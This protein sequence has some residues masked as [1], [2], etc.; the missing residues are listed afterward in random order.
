MDKILV[1][2]CS[3]TDGHDWPTHLWPDASVINMAKSGAS[4]QY[5]SDSIMQSIDL[6]SK[7]DFVFILWT[8]LN[9]LD[10]VLPVSPMTTALAETHKYYG[11]INNSYY[12]FDGGNKYVHELTQCYQQIKDSSWP[13]VN[14]LLDF[15]A[16]TPVIKQECHDAGILPMSHFDLDNLEHYLHSAFVLYRLYHKQDNK[17]FND[18]SL[19]AIANCSTFLEYHNIPYQF[20]FFADVFGKHADLVQGGIDKTNPNFTRIVWDKY[21]KLT[22][23]EFGLKYDLMSDDGFHLTADGMRQWADQLRQFLTKD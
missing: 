11:K 21:V 6:D 19:T 23:Y 5:I 1:S 7:P 12:F 8:G 4:N 20:G 16:L 17:F 22:P 9:K 13:K 10:L 2:G 3:Y 15:F 18:A 14:D